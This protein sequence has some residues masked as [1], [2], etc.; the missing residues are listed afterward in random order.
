MEGGY[1]TPHTVPAESTSAR[2]LS[3]WP[4]EFI[5]NPGCIFAIVIFEIDPGQL[6]WQ[7]WLLAG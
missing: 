1:F 3:R 6:I 4:A 7:A 5:A 2:I